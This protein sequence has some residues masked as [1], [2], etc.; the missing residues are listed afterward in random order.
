MNVANYLVCFWP[1]QLTDSFISN[2]PNDASS[3]KIEF[4]ERL[5]EFFKMAKNKQIL[6][7]SLALAGP[8]FV[9]LY[10]KISLP[11]EIFFEV[12]RIEPDFKRFHLDATFYTEL[13][14]VLFILAFLLLQRFLPS[15]R[16]LTIT[17]L[18]LVVAAALTIF[19][20]D[21][22]VMINSS[23]FE[24]PHWVIGIIG[25]GLFWFAKIALGKFLFS[26]LC[27]KNFLN[28]K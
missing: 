20:V 4:K 22:L 26:L 17:A 25:I 7:F 27:F 6:A 12:V 24:M 8:L 15:H 19:C 21:D 5:S 13:A 11:I 1:L 10:M 14:G 2:R 18:G 3:L 16:Q 9:E 23:L 28:L